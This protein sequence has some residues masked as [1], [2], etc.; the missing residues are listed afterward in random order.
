MVSEKYA[1]V[2]NFIFGCPAGWAPCAGGG[3]FVTFISLRLAPVGRGE[4]FGRGAES[5]VCVDAV[6]PLCFSRLGSLGDGDEVGVKV[7]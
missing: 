5:G 1:T 7:A 6:D 3:H 2:F 4:I